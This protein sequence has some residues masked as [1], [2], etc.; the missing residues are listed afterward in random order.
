MNNEL[1]FNRNCPVAASG[2]TPSNFEGDLNPKTPHSP[3]SILHSQLEDDE[4]IYVPQELIEAFNKILDKMKHSQEK[5]IEL[6]IK[7]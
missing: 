4:V 6:K 3:F 2:D 7:N 5:F 1:T